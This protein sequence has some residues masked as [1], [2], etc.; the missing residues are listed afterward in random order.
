M[1]IWRADLDAGRID[2]LG[3]VEPV[4]RTAPIYP[5]EILHDTLAARGVTA[6]AL[7]KA[8]D[9]PL[10]H[11]TAILAAR[12]AITADTALRLDLVLGTSATMWLGLQSDFDLELTSA[13]VD[14]MHVSVLPEFA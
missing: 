6:Y 8:M 5:G 7:A 9:I 4:L 3:I 1:P 11:I 2:F 13:M 12:R 10:T 14:E